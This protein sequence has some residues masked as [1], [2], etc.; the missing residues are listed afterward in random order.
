MFDTR[1]AAF[2]V[3]IVRQAAAMGRRIRSGMSVMKLTK[4]DLSPVTVADFAI[5]ALV[6]RAFEQ[7]FPSDPLVAE[8][9]SSELRTSEAVLDAVTHFVAEAAP[10]ANPD[11]VCRWID[12]GA[13][14]TPAGRFWTLDPIDGT[15]GY[16]RGGQYAVAL[17]LLVGG[18]VE[19]G[20]LG[21]P[22]LDKGLQPLVQP[23]AQDSGIIAI[24]QR[25]RGAAYTSLAEGGDFKP[26]RVSP[27]RDVS[28][29]RLMRSHEAGHT[30]VAQLD[31][32]VRA[33]G[34]EAA[35]VLMDSQAKYAVLAAGNAELLVRFLSP[36]APDY[37]EKIWDH[38]AGSIVIEEAGGRVTDLDGHPL[39]FTAGRA[40]RR[41]RGLLVSNGPVH[42]TALQ[43][44]A[45]VERGEA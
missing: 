11:R 9:R 44:I 4:G 43:A 5:Q 14:G 17:A 28:A 33:M 39:D 6:A 10:E 41:N 12:R 35:P 30:N 24:A 31:A 37:R 18:T 36:D 16:L 27:C 2:A 42:E 22:N 7:Q 29:A 20:V 23:A 21:C 13:G 19:F 40:L 1:E 26:L 8:E 34:I 32:F 3:S 25:G 15:K 45:H 38:A